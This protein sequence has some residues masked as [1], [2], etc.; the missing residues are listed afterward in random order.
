M[1]KPLVKRLRKELKEPFVIGGGCVCDLLMGNTPKDYDVFVDF[2]FGVKKSERPTC[3]PPN[4][5]YGE[6]G[7]DIVQLRK[8][9]GTP[10]EL[11]TL[12]PEIKITNKDVCDRFDIAICRVSIDWRMNFYISPEAQKDFDNKTL[13][14]MRLNA[15]GPHR[16]HARLI[17][18]RKKFPNFD[19]VWTPGLK[20]PKS[21]MMLRDM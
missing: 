1:L 12:K 2:D 8:H 14:V 13:T 11:I 4:V 18:M 19:E 5:E 17:R 10:V 7:N 3:L 6:L 16:V 15:N 9:D 20:Q 21:P